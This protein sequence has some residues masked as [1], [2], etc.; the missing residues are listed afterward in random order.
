MSL[1][2]NPGP[3]VRAHGTHT[4]CSFPLGLLVPQ[5]PCVSGPVGFTPTGTS[6]HSSLVLGSN[7]INSRGQATWI[8][9][10]N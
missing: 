6:D 7:S 9:L 2:P 1:V 8:G 5:H 3:S 4:G 10:G